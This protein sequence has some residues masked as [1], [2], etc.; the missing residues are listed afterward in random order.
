MRYII[1]KG[2][3]IDSIFVDAPYDTKQDAICDLNSLVV[4]ND[5]RGLEIR[6]LN[7][8][9]HVTHYSRLCLQ[10]PYNNQPIDEIVKLAI[11]AKERF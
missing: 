11:E 1:D 10:M 8:W 9:I 3:V 7:D 6:I 4:H 5:S 2:Q